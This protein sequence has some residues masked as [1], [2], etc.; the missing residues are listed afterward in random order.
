MSGD[1]K[2]FEEWCVN[3]LLD[4]DQT[5]TFVWTEAGFPVAVTTTSGRYRNLS[6]HFTGWQAGAERERGR[7]VAKITDEGLFALSEEIRKRGSDE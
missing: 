5:Y 7:I 1:R 6:D 4:A 2:A 3:D